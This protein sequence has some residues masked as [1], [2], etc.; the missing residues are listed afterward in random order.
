MENIKK[1]NVYHDDLLNLIDDYAP[2]IYDSLTEEQRD[3]VDHACDYEDIC[4]VVINDET[5]LESDKL[6]GNVFATTPLKEFI[7]SVIEEVLSEEE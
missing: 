7:D 5:V 1:V 2:E 3:L 4:F 6:S